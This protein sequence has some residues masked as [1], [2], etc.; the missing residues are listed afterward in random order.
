MTSQDSS[1]T[2]VNL[3]EAAKDIHDKIIFLLET[4]P[5]MSRGMIQVGLGPACPPRLWG[6]VLDEMVNN[7][8]VVNHDIQ[9]TS[10]NGRTMTKD[11]KHL[12]Q[13]FYPPIKGLTIKPEGEGEATAPEVHPESVA[14][15]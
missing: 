9:V 14:A 8:E 7:G 11:I 13:Y 15:E 10:P 2:T 3:E 1:A 6:P 5:Y 4:Y 12:P